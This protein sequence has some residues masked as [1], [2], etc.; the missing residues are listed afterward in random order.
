MY[1]RRKIF[2]P[3]ALTGPSKEKASGK[4]GEFGLSRI[5]ERERRQRE[6]LPLIL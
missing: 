5:L 2:P 1:S 6:I 4:S 3:W